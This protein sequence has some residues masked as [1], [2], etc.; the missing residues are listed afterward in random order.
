MKESE[1]N[2]NSKPINESFP[3]KESFE[4]FEKN[5]GQTLKDADKRLSGFFENNK[6][7]SKF[8]ESFQKVKDASKR[9]TKFIFLRLLPVYIAYYGG[10]N[11][12]QK[13]DG[14]FDEK[15]R[16]RTELEKSGTTAEQKSAYKMGLSEM[17]YRGITPFLYSENDPKTYLKILPNIL[18][19]RENKFTVDKPGVVDYDNYEAEIKIPS[20]EDAWN[21]YLGMPQKNNTFGVSDFKPEN[22]KQDK[23]YFKVNAFPEAFV[24][25]LKNKKGTKDVQIGEKLLQYVKELKSKGGTEVVVGELDDLKKLDSLMDIHAK[26]FNFSNVEDVGILLNQYTM[27]CGQDE[28][29]SYLSYYDLWDLDSPTENTQITAIGRPFEI[30]DRMY[31]DP[32]TGRILDTKE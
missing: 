24:N 8:N 3:N 28:K 29:G 5:A 9:F 13:K 27:S 16:A 10:V 26:E 20:S 6:G 4:N 23:Y 21:M 17:M 30:Y 2:T 12:T 18:F 31:Y 25:F 14:S 22:A 1:P 7:H 15:D 32:N 11:L 19:G